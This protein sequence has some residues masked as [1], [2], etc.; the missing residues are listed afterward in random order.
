MDLFSRLWRGLWN[1]RDMLFAR[2]TDIGREFGVRLIAS[3][4][5]DA[6]LLKWDRISAGKPPWLDSE[7]D[8]IS[9]NMAKHIA[10][11]RAKL[12]ALDIGISVSNADG[13]ETPSPRV[14]FLQT[15]ADDLMNRLPEKLG[16]AERLGGMM[17]KWNGQSWDYIL[18]GHFGVTE[19]D[20]NRGI[21]GA[22]FASYAVRGM[23][24]FVRLEYHRFVGGQYLVSN[25]AYRHQMMGGG[26]AYLGTRVSLKTVK[27]WEDIQEEVCIEGLTAPLFAYF[28]IPGDNTI[29][30]GSPL[31]L[32]S[33]Q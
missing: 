6:A 23:E 14:Q 19:K 4:E 12:V 33:S 32:S 24:H 22:I 20:N 11:T 8:I 15:I 30:P 1:M 27:E 2:N 29:D 26:R 28:R 10:D 18:P 25:K 9:V 16:G 3:D 5:M 17:L 31:G 7:D 13:S 21:T